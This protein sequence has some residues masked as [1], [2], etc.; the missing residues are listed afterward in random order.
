MGGSSGTPCAMGVACSG[1][2]GVYGT[3]KSPSIG[4]I[5]GAR[6]FAASW[7]DSG[8]NFWLFGGE[9]MVANG[10]NILNDLWEYNSTTGTWTW[11]GGSDTLYTKGGA[12]GV[13]GTMGTPSISN[14]PGSREYS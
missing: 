8:G 7:T 1:A 2:S 11:M 4:N 3:L 5:P 6:E 14:I 13:Y 9:G 10:G 12:S